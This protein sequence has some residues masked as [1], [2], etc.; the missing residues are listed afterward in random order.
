MYSGNI[1]VYDI[2]V[3]YYLVI[4]VKKGGGISCFIFYVMVL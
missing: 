4:V 1:N 2:D 3:C